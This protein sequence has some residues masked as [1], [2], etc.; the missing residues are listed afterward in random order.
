MLK[1]ES[2]KLTTAQFAK[3]HKI[4]K[5]T[6]HYY[7]EIDLFKPK[8]KGENNYR[9]YD[10][11]QSIELENIL[12]LKQL[13]MSISEIKS[14]LNNTNV[15]DFVNIADDKILK[16]EQDIRRL[17]QTKKVLEIKKN[18]LLKSSRVTD[19]EIEI[20]E[21]QDEYLLV[22][23]EPFVQY[24]VKEILEYLQQ[25]WNIEQYKV[26]CGSYISIDKI[27]NNDFEHYDGLFISLQNKRYGKNVLLQSKGKYLCGYVKG[28]WD[29]IAVLY[30]SML[31]FAKKE[32]LKLIGYAFERGLNEFAI[33]SIDEYFT[34]ISIKISE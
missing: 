16:I 6:L 23:N 1:N 18:Q 9:Y 29:K 33:N 5:R 14:Y 28:D 32:N 21:R 19:F 24:D 25:A 30:R 13:D 11:F 4:N 7:D 15:N 31:N 22:S 12:M 3:L 26:G 27:K 10:Y 20:V 2:L 34:E 17:K 8:F